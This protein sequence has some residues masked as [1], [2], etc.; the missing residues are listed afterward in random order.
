MKL[1][2]LLSIVLALGLCIQAFAQDVS[3]E[4]I[5]GIGN[6]H[7]LDVGRAVAT[8]A[9]GNVYVTG[10]F[11]NT[12]DFDPGSRVVNLTSSSDDGK[13]ETYV[14]KYNA[15]GNLIWAVQTKAANYNADRQATV[16]GSVT[17]DGLGNLVIAGTFSNEVDFDPGGGT[18][19]LNAVNGNKFIWKL[20]N[21]GALVWVKQIGN[22]GLPGSQEFRVITDYQNNIYVAGY[23]MNTVDFNPGQG[24][25]T[26][27][28]ISTFSTPRRQDIFLLKLDMNGDFLWV[29]RQPSIADGRI[30]GIGLSTDN[31]DNVYVAGAFTGTEDFNPGPGTHILTAGRTIPDP[32][33]STYISKFRPDGTFIWARNFRNV[34]TIIGRRSNRLGN[35][36]TDYWGNVIL[37]G[38]YYNKTDFDPGPD[39]FYMLPNPANTRYSKYIVKLDSAGSFVWAKAIFNDYNLG[40]IGINS[41]S[42]S[43]D[44]VGNIYSAGYFDGPSRD[45][46]PGTNPA[47]T[48]FLHAPVLSQALPFFLKL[49]SSGDFIWAKQFTSTGGVN[50]VLGIDVNGEGAIYSTGDFVAPTNFDPNLDT[51]LLIPNGA[52][53]DI[54]IHKMSCIDTTGKQAIIDSAICRY[55]YGDSIYTE[56]GTYYYYQLQE[57]GCRSTITLELT[58]KSLEVKINIDQNILG[59]NHSYSSYQWYFNGNPIPGATDSTYTATENGEYHVVVTDENGCIGTSETYTVNNL[60]VNSHSIRDNILLYP[61]PNDGLLFVK[62]ARPLNN[63]RFRLISILGQSL[64]TQSGLKGADF[65]FDISHQPKGIFFAEIEEDGKMLRVK[66][67]KE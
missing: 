6:T 57:S 19:L 1:R 16:S 42:V 40:S 39:S 56:S 30:F 49:N 34:D 51:V 9:Q 15:G 60:A 2:N 17:I 44:A 3:L 64:I 21:N 7:T 32:N 13:C 37:V 54:F 43:A 11:G 62:A 36:T 58:I 26:L 4:W 25:D 18:Q 35:I 28:A 24:I 27:T 41:T 33:M 48:F 29:K 53:T 12:V 61:N 45:F 10:S 47:D 52:S 50:R 66:L 38:D 65:I 5:H 46:N 31:R 14:A 23:F 55:F 8:D 67:I 22:G 63:A 59:T 20:D